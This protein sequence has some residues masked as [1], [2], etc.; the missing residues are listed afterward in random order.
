MLAINTKIYSKNQGVVVY[1][2]MDNIILEYG[3]VNLVYI[4]INSKISL[5]T[6]VSKFYYTQYLIKSKSTALNYLNKYY[7]EALTII[8]LKITFRGKG[9]RIRKF[10]KINKLTFN[11]GHSHWTRMCFLEKNMNIFRI[12][13][14]NYM[15]VVYNYSILENFVKTIKTIKKLNKYTKRGL[16]FKKQEVFRRFGKI[17]QVVSSLQR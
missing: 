9:F 17:S 5:N 12:H 15:V 7:I 8:W 13:R 11:F 4:A 2:L 3:E 10:K 1:S 14:Q 16:R 6:I